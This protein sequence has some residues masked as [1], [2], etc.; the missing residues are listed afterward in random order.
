MRTMLEHLMANV[1]FVEISQILIRAINAKLR[2]LHGWD[3]SALGKTEGVVFH[4]RH[5]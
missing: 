5:A 1:R 4:A 2:R 3:Y